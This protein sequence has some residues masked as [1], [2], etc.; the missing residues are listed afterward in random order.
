MKR[1]ALGLALVLA[2]S[3]PAGAGL[4]E[5]MAAF[6]RADYATALREFGPLAEQG[7]A[8]AQYNLGL[9]YANGHGV[10]PDDGQAAK[11]YRPAAEQGHAGAQLQLGV[12]YEFGRGVPQHFLQSYI[13][14]TLAASN[15][16]LG[17]GRDLATRNRD[18][19]AR[20]LTPAGLAWAQDQAQ[21]FNSR[22]EK[23]ARRPS[24]P[25][26]GSASP[27]PAVAGTRK[28]AGNG[29]G[30]FV[31]REGHVLTN[32]HV[33]DSCAEV[34]ARPPSGAAVKAD[35]IA[36]D[37][38]GD[39]ALLKITL[40]PAA[41]A[42]FREGRRIRQGEAVVAVGYP[43]QGLLASDANVSPGA[44]SALA[45]LGDDA[46]HLQITAPIQP[47]NSGGPLLDAS[48]NV[49]GVVVA[50]LN[51]LR[52]ARVAGT[53]PQ[54]VNF[55]IKAEL[56]TGFLLANGVLAQTAPSSVERKPADIGEAAKRFT[57]LIE[58]WK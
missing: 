13:W 9:M 30:F 48:G 40:V 57:V 36:R 33:I 28:L 26:P 52:L 11:W 34:R 44:V 14:Y 41:V 58:C 22:D 50:Q 7:V 12:M 29:S 19:V 51:A 37:A 24:A 5:G 17:D 21:N 2:A 3:A 39:L 56:A 10:P 18:K 32:E 1:L 35:I 38:R 27:A 46:R 43:L 55:A 31:S 8:P 23:A 15:L 16:P 4:E 6:R 42:S 54:N 20:R 47:G 49:V 45:G 25:S 53:I